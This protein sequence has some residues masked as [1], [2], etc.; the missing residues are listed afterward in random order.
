MKPRFSFI[1]YLYL[2]LLLLLACRMFS[3]QASRGREYSQAAAVQRWR[4]TKIYTERGDILD[5]NGIR[6]TNRSKQDIA[7]ILPADLLKDA[8]ALS[9]A[10]ELLGR[11]TGELEEA[12]A[13]S[14][15]PYSVRVSEEQ[16]N[17]IMDAGI[18]GLSILEVPVRNSEDM[19][20]AHIIGY[21]DEKGEEGLSGIEKAYQDTLK[22]G[23][24]VFAGV[25][26][27]AG[28][29]AME[30]FG[31]RIQ[32]TTGVGRLNIRTT[33]DYH[34]QE[35]VEETM[36][37]MVDRGAVVI[38]DILNGD[39]LAMASRPAFNPSDVGSALKDKAQ[40]LFNRALGEYIPGSI[41][42]IVT[43]A[44]ALE[45]GISPETSF[46]CPGYVMMGDLMMKCWNYDR[47]G[48]G[49]LN[50]AQGFAQSCNSCFISLGQM[51]GKRDIIAMAERLGLGKRTGLYLQGIGEPYGLLP[52]TMGY[53]SAA[54]TANL[55]IGQGDLLISPVQAARL[56]SVIANGGILNRVSVID[57]IVNDQGEKIRNIKS[58][59]WERVLKKET[60]EALH[61]M[62]MMTVEDGT[63]RLA[64]I[65]GFGG[66]AGKTG[67]AETGWVQDNRGVLHAWFVG[68]FPVDNPR[69]AMCV[70]I[71][72]G[73]SG[74]RSA[75]PVFAEISA[76]IL[77]LGY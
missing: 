70:F 73:A 23:G 5:R 76:R 12:A 69:Y 21:V 26:A 30:Q 35:I 8:S 16:A 63:G 77:D 37:L 60:A 34:M 48:H 25:L 56:V 51:V 6:F 62:M 43:A 13:R 31:Y 42:K 55:S 33:L 38:L 46:D 41:F 9:R 17:A 50:M 28:D 15:L 20:A 40:P 39:L 75:A 24:G 66:S 71:E 59:A 64:D 14:Y 19:L 72:D 61:R 11:Q 2:V 47:G 52:N 74:G 36:D 53:T 3:I 54:E 57:C 58:P 67:S 10:A 22:N 45:K 49:T 32:D 29:T 44:A 4:N 7:V 18:T 68:Y 27:D 1:K 65:K